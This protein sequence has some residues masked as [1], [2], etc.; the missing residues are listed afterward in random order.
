MLTPKHRMLLQAGTAC[1]SSSSPYDLE[2]AIILVLLEEHPGKSLPHLPIF[3][4]LLHH[5]HC[6]HHNK[7]LHGLVHLRN[8]RLLLR[9]ACHENCV[10][11]RDRHV[12]D[13]VAVAS[14]Y[15]C[16]VWQRR[17]PCQWYSLAALEQPLEHFFVASH[18]ADEALRSTEATKRFSNIQ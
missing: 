1:A 3:Q 13:L 6:S 14:P 5:N 8:H 12:P 17:H 7:N 11:R 2:H 4:L 9:S 16:A 15:Q 10:L 18:E